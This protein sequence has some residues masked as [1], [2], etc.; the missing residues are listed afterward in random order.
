MA[1]LL[2]DQITHQLN[3]FR[4]PRVCDPSKRDQVPYWAEEMGR[5]RGLSGKL[6]NWFLVCRTGYSCA[7][8]VVYVCNIYASADCDESPSVVY[9]EISRKYEWP[10]Y[11]QKPA[12]WK[13]GYA[14]LGGIFGLFLGATKLLKLLSRFH[15]HD[16]EMEVVWGRQ[17]LNCNRNM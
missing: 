7:S 16:T 4:H 11:T 9:W 3:I 5:I 8:C 13:G 17:V 10:Y 15:F 14:Q 1:Y 12:Y 6:F 2:N